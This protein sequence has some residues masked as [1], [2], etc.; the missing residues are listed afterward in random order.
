[1]TPQPGFRFLNIAFSNMVPT[2]E[3]NSALEETFNKATDWARYTPTSWLLW[4]NQTP[5]T[6]AERIRATPGIPNTAQMVVLPVDDVT[7][8][9]GYHQK[10]FWEWLSKER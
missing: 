10:W 6:W 9:W 1:M 3:I 8:F 7:G 5:T 4:T 2:K